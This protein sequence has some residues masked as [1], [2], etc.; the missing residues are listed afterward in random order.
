MD[1]SKEKK[2]STST[3][4]VMSDLDLP[5]DFT[6]FILSLSSSA[7]FHLGLA[8]Y[9]DGDTCCENLPM[10]K[11]TI[12]ILKMLQ[13]KTAGNLTGEEERMISDVIYN[14]QMSYVQASA[15]CECSSSDG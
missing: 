6:T 9:P 15:N 3:E 13:E 1:D 12:E 11:H 4:E 5:I 7:A 14:L 10:A 2:D 8:P